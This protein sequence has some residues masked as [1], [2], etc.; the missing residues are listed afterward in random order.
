M[1][2][3]AKCLRELAFVAFRCGKYEDVPKHL[4]AAAELDR[5]AKKAIIENRY[6]DSQP[7]DDR[8][9]WTDGGGSGSSSEGTSF[10]PIPSD[11][12]VDTL[13]KD[14]DKWINGLDSE[15]MHSLKKYTKNSGDKDDDKFYVRMNSMLRGDIPEDERLR[16]H[17]ENI[18]SALKNNKL[19]HDMICYR[20]T[21]YNPVKGLKP[22]DT[23]EPKQFLS[24]SVTKKGTLKSGKY[25]MVIRTPKGSC[26]AY[27]EGLS[28]YPKQREFL[29]DYSCKYKLI[30][31]TKKTS[32]W[33]VEIK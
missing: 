26:G 10:N 29:F 1:R 7:R 33:E 27:I 17:A 6:S 15:Q 8:G 23:Y 4:E 24:S 16:K 28:K 18:S 31:A 2:Y 19:E 32:I 21:D 30:K 22:G 13:R 12:V 9:R 25:Q 5:R 20:S 3:V 14:S 11:K